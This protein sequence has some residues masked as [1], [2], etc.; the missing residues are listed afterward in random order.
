MYLL[1]LLPG[2][3]VLLLATAFSR[4]PEV[5]FVSIVA[6]AGLLGAAYS[7]RS[8]R[9]V[10]E[11]EALAVRFGPLPLLRKRFRYADIQSAD[12]DRTSL[13]D[14]WG[15]HWVPGRGWTYNLWGFEC[16]RLTLRGGRTVRIGTDDSEGLAQFLERKLRAS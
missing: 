6:S 7:F 5:V 2:L 4:Q 11:G 8:L 3:L 10:D 13:V 1:M 9:V 15:I 12:P 14:G 16:V